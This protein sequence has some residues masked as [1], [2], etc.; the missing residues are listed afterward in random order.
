MVGVDLPLPSE[1]KP[2][3]IVDENSLFRELR[4]R[5]IY[6]DFSVFCQLNI[7]EKSCAQVG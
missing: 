6:G 2:L 7:P 3:M 1:L 4:V 5:Q